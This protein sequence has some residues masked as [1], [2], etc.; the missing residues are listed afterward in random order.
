MKPNNIFNPLVILLFS[1]IGIYSQ[2]NWEYGFIVKK[3]NDTIH[4]QIELKTINKYF[5]KIN[6]NA[7]GIITTYHPKQINS[8]SIKTEKQNLQFNSSVVKIELSDNSFSKLTNNPKPNLIIDTIFVQLLVQGAKNLYYYEDLI[9]G[10]KHF[11]IDENNGI[12][13]DLIF[14][15]Y[16]IN[17]SQTQIGYN[18]QFKGQLINHLTNCKQINFESIN[19]IKFKSDA[20]INL[21]TDYNNCFENQQASYIYKAE[22]SKVQFGLLLGGNLN[23]IQFKSSTDKINE[24]KLNQS[25]GLNLGLFI[26]IPLSKTNNKW[27][28]YN[29]LLYSSYKHTGTGYNIYF[30]N[31]TWYKKVIE[32]GISATY[33]KLF[34]A[35]QYQIQSYKLKPFIQLGISNGYAIQSKSNSNIES[36]FYSTTTEETIALIEFR[37]Y[38]Q[39]LFGGLGVNYKKVGCEVRYELGNGMSK[40]SS[41]TSRTSNLYFLI[42]YRF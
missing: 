30:N 26:N 15:K 7:N 19:T 4:G 41:L 29:E 12:L 10:N 37:K 34:T 36:R 5:E 3:N 6:F 40:I 2:G 35:L 32:V 16:Y 13:T 23:T 27:C 24:V 1:S 20:L 22:K 11:L 25:I 18:E 28:F 33:I 9:F 42:N 8:F 38:E 39:S 31:P 17:A 14:K 21:F